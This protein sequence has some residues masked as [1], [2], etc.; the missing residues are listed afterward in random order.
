MKLDSVCA[1][2]NETRSDIK[3]MTNKIY[4][5]DKEIGVVKTDLHTAFIRIDELKNK[6]E[7]MNNE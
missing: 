4:E 2:T 7:A 5:L 6:L 1:T 3:S